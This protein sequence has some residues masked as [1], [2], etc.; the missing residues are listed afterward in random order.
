M[1]YYHFLLTMDAPLRGPSARWRSSAMKVTVV[2]ILICWSIKGVI[3]IFED[4]LTDVIVI[5]SS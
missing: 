1:G 4:T 3:L 5:C 2:L